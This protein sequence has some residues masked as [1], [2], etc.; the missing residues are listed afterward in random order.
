MGEYVQ[1]GNIQVAKVLYDFV[2]EELLPNSG[3][4]QDKFWSDF[5]ALISDLTPRNKELLARR[6]FRLLF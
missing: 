6:D 2:N 5:G 4:D 1:K 3:L